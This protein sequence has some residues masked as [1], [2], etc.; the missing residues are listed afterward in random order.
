MTRQEILAK[1]RT[2]VC[3]QNEQD[4]GSPDSNF[5]LIA[6]LWSVYLGVDVT[7]LDVSMM[8]ILLKTAGVKNGAGIES[9]MVDIAGYAACGGEIVSMTDEMSVRINGENVVHLGSEN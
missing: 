3:G 7:P 5:N 4:Y 6:D 2:I 8:M 9:S 1:A